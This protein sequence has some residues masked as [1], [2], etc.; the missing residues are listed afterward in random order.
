M[1][2]CAVVEWFTFMTLFVTV[3]IAEILRAYKHR[4]SKMARV[5]VFAS[6]DNN[7][8]LEHVTIYCV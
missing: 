1:P 8:T 7:M 5:V 2:F 4:E 6:R 3:I